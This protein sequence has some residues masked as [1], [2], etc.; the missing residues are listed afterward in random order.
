[1]NGTIIA[2]LPPVLAIVMALITKE[3]YTSMLMG[4][5]AGALCASGFSLTGTLNLIIV[6]GFAGAVSA[7]AGNFCF[8]IFLSINKT[9]SQVKN[10]QVGLHQTQK[11]LHSKR[12]N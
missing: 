9:Q 6:D 4:I 3:V 7:M 8:L 11:L 10:H 2:L 1:M 12:N 5:I